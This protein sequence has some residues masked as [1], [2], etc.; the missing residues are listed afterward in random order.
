MAFPP[1]HTWAKLVSL[2]AAALML[3][4]AQ[5]EPPQVPNCYVPLGNSPSRGPRDAWVTVV[6]F[7][8]F[9]CPYCG[10]VEPAIK[11]VDL[12]RPSQVRWVWKHFPLSFHERA[13]PD[14]TA[15]ECA[16]IQNHFWEMH[17]LLFAHQGAQSDTD[18]AAYAQQLELDA[19]VWESCLSSAG[20]LERISADESDAARARV[21]GTPTF[22]V[23]GVAVVGAVPA[24]D[25]IAAVDSAEAAAMASGTSAQEFYAS[26][27]G[28]GC[29]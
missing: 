14:A 15:A 11:Q 2:A 10:Q 16:G 6:E 25:I 28:Q 22:F 7:G 21:D 5:D 1:P 18:L 19:A 8:D 27:E 26:R 17:D 4:C 3:G 23:N 24:S 12:E 13:I 20:P 29:Q 9:Q